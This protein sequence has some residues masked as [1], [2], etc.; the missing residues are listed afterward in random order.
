MDRGRQASREMRAAWGKT[1][2]QSPCS[3]VSSSAVYHRQ[4]HR[5]AAVAPRGDT[6]NTV[7]VIFISSDSGCGVDFGRGANVERVPWNICHGFHYA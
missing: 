4:D 5:R 2:L 3:L 6:A 1:S 7:V